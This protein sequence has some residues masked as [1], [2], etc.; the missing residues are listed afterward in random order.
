MSTSRRSIKSKWNSSFKST[1]SRFKRNERGQFAIMFAISSLV[2]TMASGV[3]LDTAR[4]YSAKTKLNNAVD[5]AIL[6]TTRDLTTGAIAEEDAEEAVGDFLYTNMDVNGVNGAT[7]KIDD[8]EIDTSNKTVEI[9]AHLMLPMTLTAITGWTD[10][11]VTST[12][13]AIYGDDNIEIA[14]ALDVTGSMGGNIKGASSKMAALKKAAKGSFTTFFEKESFKN[15]IRIGLVPYS[16]SVNVTPVLLKIHVTGEK[17]KGCVVERVGA[18]EYTDSFASATHPVTGIDLTTKSSRCPSNE[19]V[20]LTNDV[21]VLNDTIDG[22]GTGGTTAGHVGIAWARYMLSANWNKAWPTESQSASASAKGTKK[23]AVI[24]TDGEFNTFLSDG[25]NN[26]SKGEKKSREY[27]LGLC[28]D[29]K[30]GDIKVFTI[31]F[32]GGPKAKKLMQDCASPNTADA[33][34]FFDAS[35]ADDLEKAFQAI[36]KGITSLRLLG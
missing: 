1:V 8:I 16:A 35:D 33:Q 19:I 32:A 6:A 31:N 4:L 20:P 24:M 26:T 11:K 3:A 28:N 10:V 29:M 12:S 30:A 34:F 17:S 9:D 22:F 13:K 14:M 23:Y 15:R 27:A 5:A 7:V 2:V 18:E 25:Q 21:D 36:A